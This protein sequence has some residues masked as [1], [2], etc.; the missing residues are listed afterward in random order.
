MT[1]KLL[2]SAVEAASLLGLSERA[3]HKKRH[4]SGF[5]AAVALSARCKRFRVSDLE[6]YVAHLKEA[7]PEG[8]PHQL[9][10]S[11]G[12]GLNKNERLAGG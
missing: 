10:V 5:P 4:E 12:K 2:V 7:K 1:R 6:D 9:S 3:F 8:E 11:H